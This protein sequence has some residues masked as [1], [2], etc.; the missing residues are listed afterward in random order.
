MNTHMLHASVKCHVPLLFP[1]VFHTNLFKLFLACWSLQTAVLRR[2]GPNSTLG[3]L[4]A[5]LQTPAYGRDTNTTKKKH[6]LLQSHIT[7]ERGL[8]N[9]P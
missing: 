9:D 6:Q 3:T 2:K 1:P 5:D 7:Q 4:R 8:L